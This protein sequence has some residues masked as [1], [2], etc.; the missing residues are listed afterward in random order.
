MATTIQTNLPPEFSPIIEEIR[1]E[2]ARRL[3]STANLDIVKDA[4]KLLHKTIV[5]VSK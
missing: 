1:E 5:K 2:R 4:V 3:E